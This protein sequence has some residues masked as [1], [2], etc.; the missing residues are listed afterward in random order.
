MLKNR[1]YLGELHFGNLSNLNAHPAI[2][3]ADLF[4]R[5]QRSGAPRGRRHASD[6]L[7]A[8]LQVLRCGSCGSTMGG[9]THQKT[10]G[11]KSRLYK[12]T[13]SGAVDCPRQVAV[14][15]DLVE[16]VVADAVKQRVAHKRGK[17]STEG[18]ARRADERAHKTQANL[19]AAIR[20]FAG[21]EDEQ[22][23]QERLAE[24]RLARDDARDE[25]ER[26]RGTRASFTLDVA[27]G[28]DRLTVAEQR[29][30]IGA[31][32]KTVLVFPGRGADRIA[33]EFIE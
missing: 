30:I 4:R 11:T 12:C 13:K 31:V 10:S 27:T 17:A 18:K 1:L 24:L 28:W 8:R 2:V 33:I 29:S 16:P 6:F 25:A 14:L 5:A 3:D 7:L 32:V 19:D 26:L 15:A 20:S 23:A 21:L 9:V 22:A